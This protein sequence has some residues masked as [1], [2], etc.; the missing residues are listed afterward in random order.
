MELENLAVYS[1]DSLADGYFETDE[2]SYELKEKLKR[3]KYLKRKNGLS[4]KERAERAMLRSELKN[5]PQ[6]LSKEAKDE[7]EDIEGRGL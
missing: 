3:Y 6:N 5:I 1:S 4:D 7:F 2:Y